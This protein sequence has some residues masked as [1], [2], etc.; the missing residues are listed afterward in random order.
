MKAELTADQVS[1]ESIM[2]LPTA[3]KES[4][5]AFRLNP[6]S[7]YLLRADAAT[8][9]MSLSDLLRLIVGEWLDEPDMSGE[10]RDRI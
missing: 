5:V 2:P 9:G 6:A 3:K 4:T 8:R 1:G 7:A 10:E